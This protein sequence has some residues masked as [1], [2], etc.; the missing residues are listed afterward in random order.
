MKV[1]VLL[2]IFG[3]FFLLADIVKKQAEGFFFSK[4]TKA[5]SNKKKSNKPENKKK[6][7]KEKPRKSKEKASKEHS[8]SKTKRKSW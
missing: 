3:I 4:P 5:K 7:E 2:I 8:H 6:Q 1:V